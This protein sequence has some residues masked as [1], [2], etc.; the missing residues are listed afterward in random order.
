MRCWSRYAI[1]IETGDVAEAT[2]YRQLLS[3]SMESEYHD[4]DHTQWRHS[5][6]RQAG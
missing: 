4:L 5:I 6:L 3:S 1:D 2:S